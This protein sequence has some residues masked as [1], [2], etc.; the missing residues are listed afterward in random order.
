MYKY[1]FFLFLGVLFTSFGQVLLKTGVK[2]NKEKHFILL[3]LN[4]H[5]IL[6][7]FLLFSA[8][9]F[10]LYV[11]KFMPLKVM[12]FIV[13]L[14]F[15]LVVFFSKCLLDEKITKYQVIGSFVIILGII[16]YNI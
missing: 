1:Y 10:N 13:P 2:N 15:I 6:G 12:A 5:T 8:T 3:Y 16:I 11:L 9:L 4:F 14:S 7:Y